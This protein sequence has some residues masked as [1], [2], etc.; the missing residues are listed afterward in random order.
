MVE[1]IRNF[2][3]EFKEY[4]ISKIQMQAAKRSQAFLPSL[5]CLSH[6]IFLLSSLPLSVDS[7]RSARKAPST[8][9]TCSHR[10][11]RRCLP[12]ALKMAGR[13]LLTCKSLFS[14]SCTWTIQFMFR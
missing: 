8:P 1:L 5:L 10:L 14:L 2:P 11:E 4:Y 13:Q 7:R 9:P 6:Y 12:E 3:T